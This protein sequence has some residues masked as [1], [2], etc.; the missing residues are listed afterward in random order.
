MSYR[1]ALASLWGLV[2]DEPVLREA[3]GGAGF[4]VF[5]SFVGFWTNLAFFLGSPHYHLGAGVVGAFGLVGAAG[6]MAASPAGRLAD[7]YGAR[8]TLTAALGFLTLGYVVVWLC[9]YH[10]AGLIAGVVILD[11]GQQV[12][13]LSNQ[14]RSFALSSAARSRINTVYMIV[15]FLGA[16]VR[17][18]PFHHGLEPLG[19]ERRL[20]L[21]PDRHGPGMAAAWVGRGALQFALDYCRIAPVIRGLSLFFKP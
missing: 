9:G 19:M 13:Q 12:M 16:R 5:A 20:R 15:F 1:A 8:A 3:R 6:A 11:I 4:L 7:R 2:R 10:L 18:G 21:G 17:F 14:T